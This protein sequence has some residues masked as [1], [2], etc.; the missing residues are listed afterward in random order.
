[1]IRLRVQQYA[2][3]DFKD[4]TEVTVC[5][6]D[7]CSLVDRY[8]AHL[9]RKMQAPTVGPPVGPWT[10]L[11]VETGPRPSDGS[12]AKALAKDAEKAKARHGNESDNVG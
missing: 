12:L 5:A 8:R 10:A 6:G 2:G 1:M 9:E 4:V 7:L 11:E 3:F